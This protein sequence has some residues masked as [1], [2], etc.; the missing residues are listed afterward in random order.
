MYVSQLT[1][2]TSEML[3]EQK[4]DMCILYLRQDA[5][6]MKRVKACVELCNHG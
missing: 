1:L 2:V 4:M 6:S 5:A 3:E